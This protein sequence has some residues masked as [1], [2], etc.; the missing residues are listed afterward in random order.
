MTIVLN[1]ANNRSQI[2]EE[3]IN[4]RKEFRSARVQLW[5]HLDDAQ[6]RGCC[7]PKVALK[8]MREIESESRNIISKEFLS[9]QPFYPFIF[10]FLRRILMAEYIGIV[11]DA[12]D[13]VK[14]AVLGSYHFVDAANL[15]SKQLKAIEWE[16][17]LNKHLSESEISKLESASWD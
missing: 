3:I 9:D 15:I 13:L 8:I 7:D 11:D 5:T 10:R 17:L 14:S 16:N 6:L 2:P 1:R 4:L 12:L